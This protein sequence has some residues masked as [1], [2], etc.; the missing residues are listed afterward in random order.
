MSRPGRKSGLNLPHTRRPP[1]SA[2]PGANGS[3]RRKARRVAAGLQLLALVEQRQ[4]ALLDLVEAAQVHLHAL[5]GD[6]G[7]D[8][9]A[10]LAEELE[11]VHGGSDPRKWKGCVTSLRDIVA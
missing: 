8:L 3:K 2:R 10:I 6:A 7:F 1:A 5:E 11:I 4:A 9:V